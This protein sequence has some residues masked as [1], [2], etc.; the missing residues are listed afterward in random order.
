[1]KTSN[2]LLIGF[3][4]LILILM[5]SFSISF[6]VM[7]SKASQEIQTEQFMP[8]YNGNNDALD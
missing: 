8:D 2:K 3:F 5:I 1:M 7:Y 6:K 4:A